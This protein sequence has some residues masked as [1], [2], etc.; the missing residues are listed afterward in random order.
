MTGDLLDRGRC[1]P[2]RGHREVASEFSVP[3]SE[4]M[5]FEAA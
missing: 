1:G 5:D 2:K 3:I 4:C